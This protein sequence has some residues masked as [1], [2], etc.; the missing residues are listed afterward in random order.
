MS[1]KSSIGRMKC[2]PGLQEAR[3]RLFRMCWWTLVGGS[4]LGSCNLYLK[5]GKA[6]FRDPQAQNAGPISV[7]QFYSSFTIDDW[8]IKHHLLLLRVYSIQVSSTRV[9][10]VSQTIFPPLVPS[11]YLLL[12]YLFL[13]NQQLTIQWSL[14]NTL[15]QTWY[16]S[17]QILMI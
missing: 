1:L 13:C 7:Q 2:G 17:W 5:L 15:P 6:R 8:N 11:P 3:A 10:G 16:L 14:H 4:E 12:Y 9:L